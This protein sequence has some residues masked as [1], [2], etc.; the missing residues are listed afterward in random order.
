MLISLG[1]FFRD[2]QS[3]RGCFED[4]L[5]LAQRM[6]LLSLVHSCSRALY[7]LYKSQH[8]FEQALNHLETLHET[9][10]VL[11]DE[12][13]VRTT[14]RLLVEFELEKTQQAAELQ[15]LRNDELARANRALHEINGQNIRLLERLREQAGRLQRQ[16]TEDSLTG[17]FNRRYAE[18]QLK[19]E[20]RRA[21]RYARPLSVAVVDVDNFKVI[22]DR[23]SHA[24]PDGVLKAVADILTASIRP[25]D[26][27]ALYGGEEF[28]L[29]L[30]E[31]GASG[32]L[33]V[34][35]KL[36]RSVESYP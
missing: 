17:L 32:G 22:N 1:G 8:D 36:R 24:V 11:A 9:T 18:R 26:M 13:A 7:G 15:R 5:V 31:T 34:C 21:R 14:Q 6:K 23:F 25:A 33:A 19:R 27:A 16:A 35:E 12:R 3:A 2:Q 20:F 4:A 30:P 10:Q 29:A 28:V